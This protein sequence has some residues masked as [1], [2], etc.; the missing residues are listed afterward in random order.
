MGITTSKE[1]ELSNRTKLSVAISSKQGSTVRRTILPLAV[2]LLMLGE[3]FVAPASAD[4]TT[5]TV[6]DFS[7]TPARTA[8]RPGET[9]TWNQPGIG[10]QPHNVVFEDG[11]FSTPPRTDPWVATRTFATAGTYRYYCEIHGG[12][13]G[14]GMSGV[15]YANATGT[16]PPVAAFTVSPNPVLAGQTVTFEGSGSTATNGSIVKYEW[17]LDANGSF[18]TD[19]GAAPTTS[20]SYASPATL[21]VKLRVTDSNG[22]INEATR[23][24]QI[25]AVPQ[26]NAPLPPNAAPP[27][28]TQPQP[29]VK[30]CVVPS[31]RGKTVA[32][33]RKALRKAYCTLGQVK[34]TR[35]APRGARA[36]VSSQR[37]KKGT[38]LPADA[39]VD[40]TVKAIRHRR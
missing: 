17:D 34:R 11:Q 36:R 24:L 27:P 31:L 18:E 19:T 10:G 40:V 15:V 8:V 20:R 32:D 23:S 4:N 16:L 35:G 21:S 7:F 1:L 12:P 3:L 22:A 26:A 13:G 2:L 38:S 39:K 30:R 29:P 28:G 5:V 9:V 37:P 25:D 33:A 6:Q 14:S